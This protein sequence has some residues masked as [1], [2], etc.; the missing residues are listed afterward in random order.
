[1]IVSG[2]KLNYMYISNLKIR[3]IDS[4]NLIPISL[5]MFSKSF[6]L[7]NSEKGF[8]PY[9]FIK[10]E[11]FDY[12]GKYPDKDAYGYNEMKM[13]KQK[14]FIE[15]YNNIPNDAVF[16]FKDQISKYCIQDVNILEE[17]VENYRKL[18]KKLTTLTKK[19][20][21]D[22]DE[23]TDYEYENDEEVENENLCLPLKDQSV[24]I[25]NSEQTKKNEKK[26]ILKKKSDLTPNEKEDYELKKIK[27]PINCDPIAYCT[28]ASLCHAIYKAQFLIKN[29]IAQI[30]AGGYTNNKYSNK[31]IEWL[32]FLNFKN[33]LKIIHA[34]NSSS[35]EIRINKLRVDGFD[36]ETKTVYEF[37]GCFFHGHPK[38]IDNMNGIN[39]VSK[40]SY[41]QLLKKTIRKQKFLEN[42]GYKVI[43]IWECDWETQRKDQFVQTFL[44]Q[45][46]LIEPLNPKDAFYGGRV[47]VFKL[48]DCDSNEEKMYF[49]VTSLYPYVVARKKYP[50]GHPIILTENLGTSLLPYFGF[51]KCSILP[52]KELLIPVLP[53]K[54]NGKLLFPLCSICAEQ[55]TKDFCS[56]SDRERQLTGTWF[57][58]ELKL[59][60]EKG[61]IIKTIHEV[62]HFENQSS[63]L[64]TKFINKLYKIKLLATGKPENIN[65]DDF[66]LEMKTHEGLD[67]YNDTFEKNPG[68]RYIAKLLLNSFWGRFALRENL[69]E[70]QFIYS[71]EE[72]YKI[73][74]DESIE[75]LK[76]KPLKHN[77]AS[78][79]H[80]KKDVSLVDISNNRNIYIAAITT[81]WARIELYNY[82]DKLSTQSNSQVLYCDTD[83]IIYN[84]R[85]L[86]SKSLELGPYLGNL[87]NE[88]KINE[89]ITSYVSAGP[90]SYAYTTNLNNS[91]IK[92]KGFTLFFEN[93]KAFTKEAIQEIVEAF[94][95]K[96]INKKGFVDPPN[97]KDLAS[98]C[99]N[100]K[101]DFEKM[102]NETPDKNSAFKNYFGVS[103]YNPRSI[104]RTKD[105]IVLSRKEQKLFIF[106]YDKRLIRND[107]STL[108]YGTCLPV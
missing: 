84:T 39:P 15:W 7:K 78:V 89:H 47:E 51:I 66:L 46:R 87:T 33:K 24:I 17:G 48:L 81:A 54:I 71:A 3:I 65:F 79:I 63:K 50:V 56:H 93:L 105:F 14:N 52:P 88:L 16:N 43:S 97:Q 49:D 37:N 10:K 107:G 1:M 58:E 60:I 35:G 64:F 57:S 70:Y 29:T 12:E 69:P 72:L 2:T 8:F 41:S 18:I 19:S 92:I 4:L 11:N 90:K 85:S 73:I 59:A 103:V 32:E 40:V 23:L 80:K 28:L 75:I 74:E 53:V 108:P 106:T 67:L 91:C 42:R 22:D 45:K 34:R 62:Y 31:S 96:Y 102:H 77:L 21:E 6:G 76:A 20:K 95:K 55:Q 26:K 36:A 38:C 101:E 30:P 83:S 94:I 27:T 61:Y 5:D 104:S 68:L 44:D 98:A 82:M 25:I 86:P 13:N 9:K 100:I 99:E